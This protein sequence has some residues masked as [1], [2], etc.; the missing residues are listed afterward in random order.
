[1]GSETNPTAK[2]TSPEAAAD[3]LLTEF[4][5][6][7]DANYVMRRIASIMPVALVAIALLVSRPNWIDREVSLAIVG[8][9][10]AAS[11]GFL[12]GVIKLGFKLSKTTLELQY[13]LNLLVSEAETNKLTAQRLYAESQKIDF[14]SQKLKFDAMEAEVRKMLDQSGKNQS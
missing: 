2:P 8:G 13:Q 1:M 11:V 3:L 14:E 12:F 6:Q 4:R 9:L 10:V 7:V 5:K